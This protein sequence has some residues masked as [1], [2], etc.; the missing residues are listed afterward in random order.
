M[1]PVPKMRIRIFTFLI[2][3]RSDHRVIIIY[4]AIPAQAGSSVILTATNNRASRLRGNDPV[5][6]DPINVSSGS[7]LR[8]RDAAWGRARQ[9]VRST[10]PPACLVHR[11]IAG[12]DWRYR[13]S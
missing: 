4:G 1:P 12:T 9:A 7:L 10:H 8:A 3:H 6:D 5:A 11:A 2:D 13:P